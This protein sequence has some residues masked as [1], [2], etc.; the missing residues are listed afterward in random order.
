[1]VH[2]ADLPS[3]VCTES[4]VGYAHYAWLAAYDAVAK[5]YGLSLT[6]L[7]LGWCYTRKY[8]TSTI[9]GATTIDQLRENLESLKVKL[10][11]E[12]LDDIHQV[13]LEYRDPA[14]YISA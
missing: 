2:Y 7:A 6:Q 3:K 12:M 11:K 9:I 14:R 5:K 13:Y 8:V 4:C 1:M 10:N